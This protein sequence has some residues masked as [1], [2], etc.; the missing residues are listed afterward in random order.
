MSQECASSRRR[1]RGMRR[2][3]LRRETCSLAVQQRREAAN[4]SQLIDE[5]AKS[6]VI[7]S[8]TKELS[9]VIRHFRNLIHPGRMMRLDERVDGESATIAASLVNIIVDELSRAFSKAYGLTADQL[10]EKLRIN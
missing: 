6:G 9:S 1:H 8:K 2:D 4:L 7:T 10:I 5:L 3:I